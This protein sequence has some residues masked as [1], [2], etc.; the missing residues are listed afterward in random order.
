[1]GCIY[2]VIIPGRGMACGPGGASSVGAATMSDSLAGPGD[3]DSLAEPGDSGEP[4]CAALLD[5]DPQ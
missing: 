4:E 5:A 3:S 2:D 1:M